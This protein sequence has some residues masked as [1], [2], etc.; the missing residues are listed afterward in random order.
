MR[1]LSENT[2]ELNRVYTI[3]LGK[4][5]TS[6]RYRRSVRAIHMIQEFAKKHMKTENAII[7][8]EVNE[9][10]WKKGAGSPP[11]RIIVNIVKSGD[12]IVKVSL[13][14][15]TS[16]LKPDDEVSP[17]DEKTT[18]NIANETVDENEVVRKEDVKESQTPEK[19]IEESMSGQVEE[20][21]LNPEEENPLSLD[22]EK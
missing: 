10:V 18:G 15:E 1:T 13:P 19:V 6:P 4:A 7:S 12:G 5:W 22:K 21:G 8:T 16:E 17:P 2:L 20:S 9:H 11:R 14:T 3:P